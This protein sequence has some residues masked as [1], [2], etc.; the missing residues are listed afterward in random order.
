MKFEISNCAFGEIYHAAF[1]YKLE[2]SVTLEFKDFPIGKH[3]FE[4]FFEEKKREPDPKEAPKPLGET[5]NIIRDRY[6]E[7][8]RQE[9]AEKILRRADS[10]NWQL[11]HSFRNLINTE[12]KV[13]LWHRNKQY[14]SHRNSGT[15]L[16]NQLAELCRKHSTLPIL[17]GPLLPAHNCHELGEFWTDGFFNEHSIAK[18]LWCINRLFERGG[19]IANVGVMS[20]AMDGSA[21]VFGHKTVFLARHADATPRMQKVTAS[22]PNLIWQ[23]IDFTG[24]LVRLNDSDLSAVERRIWC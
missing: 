2:T 21:M 11:P 1:A 9:I 15:M 4:E 6:H 22:V 23:Q 10:E 16:I 13:L 18:Q 19:G 14:K 7:G 8:I 5:A 17:V 12:P 3:F 20:G 24:N